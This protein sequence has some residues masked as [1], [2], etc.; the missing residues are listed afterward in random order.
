MPRFYKCNY[1]LFNYISQAHAQ[2][3]NHLS[4]FHIPQLFRK[5]AYEVVDRLLVFNV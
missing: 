5:V 3:A 1:V 2:R 4:C